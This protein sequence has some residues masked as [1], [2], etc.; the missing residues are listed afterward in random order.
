MGCCRSRPRARPKTKDKS[1]VRYLIHVTGEG[2]IDQLDEGQRP[3]QTEDKI[4][5][6]L[7]N[8]MTESAR[9]Y[10][11]A[12]DSESRER[13]LTMSTVLNKDKRYWEFEFKG[14]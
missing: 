4:T 8:E 11:D 10:S 12:A 6:P 5:T 2:E 9:H 3:E 1:K 7:I 14:T 13:A